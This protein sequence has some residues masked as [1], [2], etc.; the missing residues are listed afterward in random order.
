LLSGGGCLGCAE[1]ELVDVRQA[2]A[3]LQGDVDP[4]FSSCCSQAFGIAKS[5]LIK[6]RPGR[7]A[8]IVSVWSLRGVLP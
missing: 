1:Q 8:V 5:L 7:R 4:G 3:D 6:G 2:V